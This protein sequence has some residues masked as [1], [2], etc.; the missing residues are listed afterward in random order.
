MTGGRGPRP[1]VLGALCAAGLALLNFPLLTIWDGP[2]SL[3]GLPPLP[4]A[5]FAI[6]LGLIVALALAS[7]GGGAPGGGDGAR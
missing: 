7:R 5:L 3:F 1:A 2:G 6:W 4:V